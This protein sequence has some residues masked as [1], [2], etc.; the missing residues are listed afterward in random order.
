[1]DKNKDFYTPKEFA[2]ITGMNLMTVYSWIRKGDL[3]TLQKTKQHKHL[4]PA[5]ELP[6][7]KRTEGK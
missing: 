1:M 5:F 4:I 2:E 3:Q 7:F 6:S